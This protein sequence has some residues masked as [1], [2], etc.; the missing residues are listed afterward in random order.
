MEV[1]L[2][3]PEGEKL[4]SHGGEYDV[5]VAHTVDADANED[6]CG[7]KG[8]EAHPPVGFKVRVPGSPVDIL[9][10]KCADAEHGADDAE[11]EEE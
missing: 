1:F 5:G 9:V 2:R 4:Y 8:D 3:F 7:D 6:G 11:E 10:E